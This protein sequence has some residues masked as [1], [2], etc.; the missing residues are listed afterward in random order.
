[1]NILCSFIPQKIFTNI[2]MT[3]INNIKDK[4]D[5]ANIKYRKFPLCIAKKFIILHM[6]K[7]RYFANIKNNFII[8][9]HALKIILNKSCIYKKIDKDLFL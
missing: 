9:Y 1:M 6:I 7:N 2:D 8:F 4:S 5:I 3:L